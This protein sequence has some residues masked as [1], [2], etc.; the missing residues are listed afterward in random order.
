[1]VKPELLCHQA[2]LLR[3]AGRANDLAAVHM[4]RDHA[5][6]GAHCTGS[7]AHPKGVAILGP[8][9]ANKAAI[10]C[11]AGH[12]QDPDTQAD[13]TLADEASQLAER[14]S[15]ERRGAHRLHRREGQHGAEEIAGLPLWQLRL[16][17][18]ATDEANHWPPGLEVAHGSDP[19][20]HVR[21]C[22]DGQQLHQQPIR[23][24]GQRC[25]HHLEVLWPRNAFI[26]IGF[27]DHRLSHGPED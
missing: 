25:F 18:S 26:Q 12:A 1:M 2:A 4:L 24:G 3:A 6:H 23:H 8:Q 11:S 10:G 16:Q 13:L 21:V 15:L 20:S 19:S 22:A 17:D 5:H 27:E 14:V 9:H 7:P